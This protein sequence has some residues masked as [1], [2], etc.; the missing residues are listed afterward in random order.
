MHTLNT[1]FVLRLTGLVNDAKLEHEKMLEFIE[2]MD[3]KNEEAHH[4]AND[5]E[6]VHWRKL[7]MLKDLLRSY[8]DLA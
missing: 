5:L 1:D 7:C 6:R 3:Q 4:I 8:I 2:K